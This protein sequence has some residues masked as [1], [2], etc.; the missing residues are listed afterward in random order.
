[1]A[2]PERLHSRGEKKRG[3][4]RPIGAALPGTA[5]CHSTALARHPSGGGIVVTTGPAWSV[6]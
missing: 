4:S 5:Q 3:V 6:Q 2:Q 1:M